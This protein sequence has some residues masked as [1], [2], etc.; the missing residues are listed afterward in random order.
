VPAGD[1]ARVQALVHEP[2]FFEDLD[3][4][5][6]SREAVLELTRHYEVFIASA[7]MEVPNSLAAKYRWLRR[8]FPFIPPSHVVFCG[9]KSVLDADYLIDDTPRQLRRF[10]GTPV[11]FS[12]PHNRDAAGYLRAADWDEVRRLLLPSEG[13]SPGR[14]EASARGV[15]G[16][17]RPPV[18]TSE[19]RPEA[20]R[21]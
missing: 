17:G 11:L 12:A 6:G 7:A 8:H 1:A 16:L 15:R 9:D 19:P 13:A 4:I 2:G 18:A 21:V 14:A 20:G 5:E 10:R 3:V